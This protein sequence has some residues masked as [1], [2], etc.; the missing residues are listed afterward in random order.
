MVTVFE[1]LFQRSIA[2]KDEV[3]LAKCIAEMNAELHGDGLSFDKY[4]D[5]LCRYDKSKYLKK[6][7]RPAVMYVYRRFMESA[8]GPAE[9]D[10]RYYEDV[11]ANKKCYNIYFPSL[12]SLH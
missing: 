7:P 10:F 4:Y 11:I 1:P 5:I 6:L 2:L 8:T 3:S 9:N 12:R